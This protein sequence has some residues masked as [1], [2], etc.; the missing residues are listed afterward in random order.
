MTGE[1]SKAMPNDPTNLMGE[2][3][4][5]GWGKNPQLDR[6]E[7]PSKKA[8]FPPP[9]TESTHQTTKEMTQRA[10]D[11]LEKAREKMPIPPTLLE[12]LAVEA[13]ENRLPIGMKVNKDGSSWRHLIEAEKQKL[14]E[15]YR[16]S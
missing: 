14:L 5:T 3:P 12:A 7:T 2:I 10:P 8:E 13:A 1:A 4:P 11:P 15:V 16:V 6:G 9:I